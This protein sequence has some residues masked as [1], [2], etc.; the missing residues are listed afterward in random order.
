MIHCSRYMAIP[1]VAD[2]RWAEAVVLDRVL[3]PAERTVAAAAVLGHSILVAVADVE[4]VLAHRVPE[5]GSERSL[6]AAA[7]QLN[8]LP[9]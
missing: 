7:V 5:S 2:N 6:A 9:V 4:V 8:N 1:T 3:P